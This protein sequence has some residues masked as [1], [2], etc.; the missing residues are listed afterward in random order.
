MKRILHLLAFVLT[1]ALL[2]SCDTGF[3]ST[4]QVIDKNTKQPIEAVR[5][6]AKGFDTTFTD[7]AGKYE[8]Q[9]FVCGYAGNLELLLEKEGYKSKH[10][11]FKSGIEKNPVLI[12][13]EKSVDGKAVCVDRV[14]VKRLF[15]FNQY[16]FPLLNLLTLIF[17]AAKRNL[18]WKFAFIPGIL[19]LNFY[20]QFSFTD[21][22]FVGINYMIGLLWP[23]YHPY[24]LS[25]VVPFATLLFWG[26]FL[27]RKNLIF[28]KE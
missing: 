24:S 4:G 16:F 21:F 15:H 17:V 14:W 18:R 8:I 26:L 28:R 13:L 1:G 11:S 7:S 6:D 19:L 25:L 27:F 10:I 20:I 23:F 3:F 9:K 12:E 2:T 5:I 22:S